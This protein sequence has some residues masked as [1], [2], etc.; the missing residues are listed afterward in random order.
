MMDKYKVGDKIRV[1]RFGKCE[2]RDGVCDGVAPEA[3]MIDGTRVDLLKKLGV[4]KMGEFINTIYNDNGEFIN[5]IYN[6]NKES[7][8]VWKVSNEKNLK[9]HSICERVIQRVDWVDEGLWVI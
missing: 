2:Y 8:W 3:N 4:C 1:K 5:T 9:Q 6:D 7:Y